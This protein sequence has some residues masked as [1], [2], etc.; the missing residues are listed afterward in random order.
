ME[1]L[2]R[3]YDRA[4]LAVKNVPD[5]ARAVFVTIHMTYL[6]HDRVFSPLSMTDRRMSEA[7]SILL[8]FLR[9]IK[10]D[11]IVN[12][13][14]DVQYVHAKIHNQGT[15]QLKLSDLMRW[16]EIETQ[17]ADFC[18]NAVIGPQRPQIDP[19][20]YPYEHSPIFAVRQDRSALF[21]YAFEPNVPRI[22]ASFPI[23]EVRRQ[24]DA[25]RR[26]AMT[27]ETNT[28]VKLASER[29]AVF[30]PLTIDE[31]PLGKADILNG[32]SSRDGGNSLDLPKSLRWD[33]ESDDC[34][35]QRPIA[36]IPG[37]PRAEL[38]DLATAT[39]DGRSIIRRQVEF[40]DYR[41]IDQ[42]DAMVIYRPTRKTNG[43]WSGGTRAEYN[44]ARQRMKDRPNFRIY[45]I[46]DTVD[47]ELGADVVPDGVQ[48]LRAH[49]D[50]VTVIKQ[51]DLHEHARQ[52]ATVNKLYEIISHHA[53]QLVAD[54]VQATLQQPD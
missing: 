3:V 15:E 26:E 45:I 13:I 8:E 21:R 36:D 35:C 11:L 7:H 32:L 54:R 38:L 37:I 51:A 43:E 46:R 42:S 50:R 17:I 52:V 30:N 6:Y 34:I 33:I 5:S 12:L 53:T 9:K 27:R 1:L 22:Y 20:V 41:L 40:R 14:D 16:R 39:I 28:F 47:G 23:S 44:Y 18:A 2:R 48:T 4:A 31:L 49:S 19:V 25:A 10:P 29:W 24:T